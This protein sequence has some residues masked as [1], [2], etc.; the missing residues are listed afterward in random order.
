MTIKVNVTRANLAEGESAGPVHAPFFPGTRKEGEFFKNH[1]TTTFVMVFVCVCV[2]VDGWVDRWVNEGGCA[3][4]VLPG[5][6]E[7]GCVRARVL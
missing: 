3:R 1:I 2:C 6:A 4:P 5:D 7:G